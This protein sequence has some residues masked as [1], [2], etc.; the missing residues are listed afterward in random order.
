M[1][2]MRDPFSMPVGARLQLG[3]NAPA[4]TS[5]W[6][7]TGNSAHG[8]QTRPTCLVR[9]RPKRLEGPEMSESVRGTWAGAHQRGANAA[10]HLLAAGSGPLTVAISAL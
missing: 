3:C 4:I 8:A 9:S 2:A 1:L 10:I 7:E 6:F 5:A